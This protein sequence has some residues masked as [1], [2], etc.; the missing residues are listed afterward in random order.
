MYQAQ[1]PLQGR[2]LYSSYQLGLRLLQLWEATSAQEH[3]AFTM[4]EGKEGNK[5]PTVLVQHRSAP[6][7]PRRAG[8]ERDFVPSLQHI[9][10]S[11]SDPSCFH[12]PL[13][14][15]VEPS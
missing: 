5:V 13:S 15:A 12:I 1:I 6:G 7:L 11:R 2:T 14:R 10:A 9:S 4:T 8:I 3:M